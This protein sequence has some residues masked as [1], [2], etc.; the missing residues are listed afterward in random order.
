[1]F[2]PGGPQASKD[3]TCDF[4]NN[5]ILAEA[6][7]R[8]APGPNLPQKLHAHVTANRADL[9][10]T[11]ARRMVEM[12]GEAFEITIVVSMLVVVGY[13]STLMTIEALRARP[14]APGPG[15][16]VPA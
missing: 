10:L 2:F 13:P 5:V 7:A 9:A 15:R 6:R 16:A 8:G 4:P 11:Q 1:M 12:I 3:I 14:Q